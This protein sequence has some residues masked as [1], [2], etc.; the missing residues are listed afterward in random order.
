MVF[1]VVFVGSGESTP[2]ESK[3]GSLQVYPRAWRKREANRLLVCVET[4]EQW[5]S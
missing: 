2:F 1:A 5:Q 4:D 3:W